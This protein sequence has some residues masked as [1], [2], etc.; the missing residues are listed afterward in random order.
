MVISRRIG[1]LMTKESPTQASLEWG[2]QSGFLLR[3]EV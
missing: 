3:L 2:T 1:A